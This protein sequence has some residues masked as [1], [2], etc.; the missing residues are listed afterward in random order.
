MQGLLD[1]DALWLAIIA[2]LDAA[3]GLVYYTCR[4]AVLS[5]GRHSAS[6][7]PAVT[8]C[9]VALT[10]TAATALGFAPQLVLSI[11]GG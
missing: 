9:L 7:E 1:G 11:V 6:E 3:I 5:D 8:P 2:A 10:R 4:A